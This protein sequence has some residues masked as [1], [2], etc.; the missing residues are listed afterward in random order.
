MGGKAFFLDQD[1][2]AGAPTNGNESD[3]AKEKAV[4]HSVAFEEDKKYVAQH[5][6]SNNQ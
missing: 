5:L 2:F 1:I 6:L 3:K 4:P